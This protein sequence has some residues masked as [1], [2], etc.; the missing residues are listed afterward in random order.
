[1]GLGGP[2]AIGAILGALADPSAEVREAA[3]EALKELGIEVTQLENG[4]NVVRG[5]DFGTGLGVGM[6]ALQASKPPHVPVFEV[7]GAGHTSYLRTGTGDVYERGRWSQLDPVDVV[8][9]TNWPFSNVLNETLNEWAATGDRPLPPTWDPTRLTPEARHESWLTAYPYGSETQFAAGTAPVSQPLV[10]VSQHGLYRPYSGTFH[11][12]IPTESIKWKAESREFRIDDLTGARAYADSHYVSLPEGLPERIGVLA[13][14]ITEGETGTYA[15][16]KAIEEYLESN[17]SYAF[18]QPGGPRPPPGRDPVDWFLFD[19]REGTCGVFSSAF[20][21]LARSVGVPARVVSGWAIGQTDDLQ[22][23]YLDQAHQWAEVALDGIGWVAFEPTPGGAPD[24][25]QDFY[26]NEY[27]DAEVEEPE[28]ED[29]TRLPESAIREIR[30]RID[31]SLEILDE[32]SGVGLF[33]L[34]WTLGDTRP[35]YEEVALDLLEERGASITE[36]ENGASLLIYE[37]LGYWVPGT[38]TAQA[39]GLAHNPIFEVHGAGHTNYLRT[40]VG[41]VY[42]NGRWRQMHPTGL[43]VFPGESVPEAVRREMENPDSG[44]SRLP[45]ER[46]DVALLT[47][48][49]TTPFEV[50]TDVIRMTP[51]GS[52]EAFP[53]GPL[54][55]SLHVH[56]IDTLSYLWAHN[57][58]FFSAEP[59]PEHSWTSKIPVYSEAQLRRAAA[60]SDPT[61]VQLPPSVPDRVRLLAQEVTEG[62]TSP[63]MKAKALER[64]LSTTYPYAFADSSDDAPPPGRDPVDWFLFEHREG[65]CGV[66]S[67]AFVV[68]ARSVGIPARVVSGWMIADHS[69]TQTVYSDQGHQWAEVALDGIGWVT[70][71]ATAS[72]GAPTRVI[73][74]RGDLVHSGSTTIR[75]E[76]NTT[77]DQSPESTRRGAPFT[78]GGTVM[79]LSGAPVDGMEVEIFINEKKEQGGWRIGRGETESGRF[80]IEVA[81]PARFEGGPYQLIAHAIG[82]EDYVGSW[83]DPEIGVYSGTDLELIGP[84]EISVDEEGAFRGRLTEEAGDPLKDRLL[85]VSIEGETPFQVTTDDGG[86]FSFG[87]TFNRTGERTVEVAFEQQEYMLGNEARLTVMVTMPT[88]VSI[89]AVDDVQ[90]GE[91]Y[92]IRGTLRD[93]RGRGLADQQVDIILPEAVVTSVQTDRRGEFT[94]RSITEQ[95]GRYGIEAS[96]AGDR[97]L[98]PSK[99]GYTLSVTEPAYLEL[100]GDKEVRVGEEYTARGTLKDSRDAPLPLRLIEVTL[101][102]GSTASILTDEQGEFEASGTAERAGRYGIEASF[103]GDGILGSSGG[104]YTLSVI[105]PVFL[106]L[107]GSREVQV[108]ETHMVRGSLRDSRGAPLARKRVLVTV[109]EEVETPVLTD[110]QGE[111]VM[112]I[113]PVG[114]GR[115][116]IEA[117][118]AG[119]DTLEP[120]K[121]GYVL[122]VIEPVLLELSGDRVARVDAPYRLEG[123][124]SGAGGEGLEGYVLTLSAGQ[125]DP[126]EV[127]TGPL[128]TFTWETTFEE[129]EGTTSLVVKFDGTDD[130]GPTQATLLTEVGRAE[131]VVEEPEPVARGDTVTIGGVAV[132]NGQAI[133][134]ARIEVNGEQ[135]GRTNAAGAFVV[136]TPVPR[137]AELG[138]MDLRVSAAELEAET[139]VTVSVMSATSVLVTPVDDVRAGRSAQVEAQVLDDRGVGIPGAVVH[140]G[141]EGRAVTDDL[142]VAL[143]KVDIPDEE[144]L[145]S[146]PLR[147]SYEGDGANLPVAY[148]ASLQVEGGGSGWLIWAL[149][150]VA[151]LLGIGGGYLGRRRF[152]RH[153]ILAPVRVAGPDVVSDKTTSGDE[154]RSEVTHLEMGFV[155]PSP[156]TENAWQVGEKVEVWCRLTDDSGRG[157]EGAA[158]L[159]TWGDGEAETTPV[160]DRKGRCSASWVGDEAGMYRVRAEFT[161]A[162]RYRAS[163]TSEGFELRVLTPTRLEVSFVKSAEDLPEI[164]GVGEEVRIT[165]ALVDATG[166][167]LAGRRTSVVIGDT[168]E[169]EETLTD[170]SGHCQLVRTGEWPGV[171]SV[172]AEFDGDEGYLPSEGRGR[173][174]VVD[175]RDDVVQRYNSFLAKVRQKVSGISAKATPREVEAIVVGSGMSLDQR[176]LEEL[177]ARFEE[178]DYS[179]HD[180]GRRQFEA[181]YRAWRRLEEE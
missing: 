146:V 79:T 82:N 169:A 40:S 45:P 37:N 8:T 93:A 58:T 50:R 73:Q 180:I 129:E 154:R 124:L 90:V 114:A 63:Y 25:T 111:F 27:D 81:V 122:R 32:D 109:S 144:G 118:F 30:D 47:G 155:K 94:V 161:G 132:I 143:L 130:L 131:I 179:E 150:P 18:A 88:V 159:I 33:V 95:P 77:I 66:F 115:Q 55:T 6:T 158:V 148:L 126:V 5:E 89:G 26:G 105:E 101:A 153:P 92:V 51:I 54:P 7:S 140:Y 141:G 84:S 83:S 128:G 178:A 171:Y 9:G 35:G 91:E 2:K 78:V 48:F 44:F 175:F 23:V 96:F 80:E 15:K 38:T 98:E 168:G 24:R 65:T 117:S 125:G 72:G 43:W 75:R 56:S 104:G 39:P 181:A 60:S 10:S 166:R 142:G 112:N 64:Y 133:P 147:V 71:E 100:T 31:E 53:D 121:T 156:D 3:A 176:A 1:M 69:G 113:V 137:D 160:T 87:R 42:E 163:E 110:E 102:D 17:Y 74:A 145:T 157:I 36:L 108:G 136:R 52:L 119:D 46:L 20:V 68:M 165:V 138:K 106:E 14:E 107:S 149:L 164:W 19:R 139:E 11:S 174:Q 13:R 123:T 85:R 86:A 170:D 70:F 57:A 162:E 127:T 99:I 167:G 67:S 16:A 41:D 177:I 103:S 12:A 29:Q 135:S 49:Q 21:V 120:A 59:V 152:G 28:E 76:T 172:E 134:D 62:Y 151:L 116:G 173:F 4:G 61:Y 22:T 34:E 97:V